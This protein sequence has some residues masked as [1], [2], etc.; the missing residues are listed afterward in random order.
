MD[1]TVSSPALDG[2]VDVRDDA[3]PVLE[4]CV[5]DGI[6]RLQ[7]ARLEPALGQPNGLRSTDADSVLV[8]RD[9]PGDRD[10]D[11]GI[12]PRED[13]DARLRIA[14]APRDSFD[15]PD[16][17]ADVEQGRSLYLGLLVR[18]EPAEDRLG[19]DGIG[20]RAAVR[21]E[22]APEAERAP[23]AGVAHGGADRAAFTH[24][25][26]VERALLAEDA[27][28]DV[29]VHPVRRKPERQLADEQRALADGA[30]LRLHGAHSPHGGENYRPSA[31][32]FSRETRS[33]S[34]VPRPSPPRGPSSSRR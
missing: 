12:R 8:P 27:D 13:D 21:A 33:V 24:P 19:D 32:I 3:R 14:Q 4:A 6:G 23:A 7:L 16:R 18:R 20:H 28:V 31:G 2:I 9:L 15:R 1:R 30:L 17:V 29:L 5:P 26:V 25:A 10:H 22:D 34:L 11:L